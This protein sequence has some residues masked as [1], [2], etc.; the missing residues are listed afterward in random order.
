MPYG[1]TYHNPQLGGDQLESSS[2]DSKDDVAAIVYSFYQRCMEYRHKTG[3]SQRMRWAYRYLTS[4]RP[5]HIRMSTGSS[6]HE[7]KNRDHYEEEYCDD[8]ITVNL[9]FIGSQFNIALSVYQDALKFRGTDYVTI[10]PTPIAD[11][12]DESK[13]RIRNSAFNSIVREVLG[14]AVNVSGTPEEQNIIALEVLHNLMGTDDGLSQIDE[15]ISRQRQVETSRTFAE[16]NVKAR[17][18]KSLVDDLLTESN[19]DDVMMVYGHQAFW[20]D[21]GVIRAPFK[22]QKKVT[23][24]TSKGLLRE[25]KKDVWCME[26]V[27]PMNHFYAEDT[28]FYDMGSGE[29]DVAWLSRGAISQLESIDGGQSDAISHVLENFKTYTYGYTEDSEH[30]DDH[31]DDW[32]YGDNIPVIR[33][34]MRL[35]SDTLNSIFGSGSVDAGSSIAE[36]WVVQDQCIYMKLEPRYLDYNPYRKN[37]YKIKDLSEMSSSRGIY[38]LLRSAQELIDNAA[39]NVFDNLQKLP[40]YITEINRSKLK[41]PDEVEEEL[42]S[43]RPIIYTSSSG[44]R[45]EFGG[46]DRAVNIIGVPNN[47][48]VYLTAMREGIS[49]MQQLGFSPFALG[50]QN[51]SN[52]RSTGLGAILQQN[53]N[54]DF[55]RFLQAQEDLIETPLAKYIWVAEAIERKD[56]SIIVDGDI[57][58]QSYTGFLQKDTEAENIGLFAQNIAALMGQR[59]VLLQS[60]QD[61]G[62]FDGLITQYTEANGFDS[63]SLPF[64]PDV[65]GLGESA[66]ATVNDVTSNIGT[67]LDGRN[68]VPEGINQI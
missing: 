56:P 13:D 65:G 6:D 46:N 67:E 34:I 20:Y 17:N 39:V 59:N 14:Q 12:S 48:D 26:N 37:G 66:T 61:T 25:A 24:I 31:M 1:I 32:E 68:N 42:E 51:L 18:A 43:D 28:S 57:V 47:I 8:D 63:G 4:D 38:S 44:Y 55:S 40:N 64:G 23:E 45:A 21:Y 36:F 5:T 16:A 19:Y 3:V 50:Q 10:E 49:L 7:D 27:H 15:F 2:A 29:G 52:V 30:E 22:S 62:W 41:E 58:I 9:D 53:A 35:D 33:T 11:V 54:K 60:G